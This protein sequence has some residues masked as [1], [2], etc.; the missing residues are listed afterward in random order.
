[1]GPLLRTVLDEDLLQRVSAICPKVTTPS[2]AR[3]RNGAHKARVHVVRQ[4]SADLA[5]DDGEAM[6]SQ[7]LLGMLQLLELHEGEVKV[8]EQ[9]ST[10]WREARGQPH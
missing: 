5:L 9:R 4:R 8:L 7:R 10:R 2:G 1:M 6:L 3:L